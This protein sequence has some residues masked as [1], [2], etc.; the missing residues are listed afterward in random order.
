[1]KTCTGCESEMAAEA[2]NCPHC[3][4]DQRSWSGRRAEKRRI[5]GLVESVP[6]SRAEWIIDAL[7]LAFIVIVVIVP[8]RSVLVAMGR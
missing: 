2:T 3:G 6:W 8:L 4:A 1:M 5:L 7:A